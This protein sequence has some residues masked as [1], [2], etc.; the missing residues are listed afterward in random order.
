MTMLKPEQNPS[1]AWRSIEGE[2]VVIS[3]EEGIMH[4]LNETASFIWNLADGK[5]TSV[6]IA[7]RLAEEFEVPLEVACADTEELIALLRDRHLLLDSSGV[8]GPGNA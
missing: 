3:P 4:E 8:E 1:L 6:E 2:V 5:H 7:N